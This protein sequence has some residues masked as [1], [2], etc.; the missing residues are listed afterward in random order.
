MIACLLLGDVVTLAVSGF[1][2]ILLKLIPTGHLSSWPAYLWLAPLLPV[3]V[4]V[5][6]AIG[7]YSG[8]SM[9]SPE[10]L[11]RLTLSS[12]LV[13]LLLGVLTLSFRGTGTVFT[14]TMLRALLISV[15]LV[16]LARVCVRLKFSKVSWWGYPTVV[17]AE[18][19]NGETVLRSLMDD[20]GLGLKPVAFSSP[21]YNKPDLLGVPA[22]SLD[23]LGEFARQIQGP[24]YA[25]LAPSSGTRERLTDLI[26]CYRPLFSH[27]VVIPGISRFS[28]LWVAPKNLGGMLGLEVCQQVFLPS[29][30]F[31]KRAIDL[32]LTAVLGLLFAPLILLITVAI[33][34]DSPGPALYRQRRIGRG[35][36]EFFAWKFRSMVVNADQILG[37]YLQ[38]NPQALAEWESSHKLKSDPRVTRLGRFLRRSS[39]D[40]IP[41]LWNVIRGEMSLVGPRPIVREEIRHYGTD[42]EI[43]TW[44]PGGLTGLWQVSGRSE[45]S[46]QQRVDYDR[47]YVDNW[48][49]WLDLCILFRTIGIVLSR[50]GAF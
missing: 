22:I 24:A 32:V 36:R 19:A 14:G 41:Q 45:T 30:Q 18:A 6:S 31:L 7:L 29:Q 5:Y 1:V 26:E 47:F 17:V 42:F 28:C 48:S 38:S 15:I 33:K 20:P 27:I 40:E 37:S 50:A 8:I 49:V 3:F 34:L 25:V 13:S 12:I 11:R 10:E 23:E 39:L 43:Y 4:L 46:Y 35:G 21:A 44:V 16:P 9:G 2:A